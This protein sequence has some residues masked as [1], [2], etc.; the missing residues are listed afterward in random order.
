M[1]PIYVPFHSLPKPT[2]LNDL[3]SLA[4]LLVLFS[5][6]RRIDFRKLFSLVRGRLHTFH[7]MFLDATSHNLNH[8][9]EIFEKSYPYF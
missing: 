6:L 2:G 5:I 4:E 9:M 8:Q 1:Y 7:I 3:L